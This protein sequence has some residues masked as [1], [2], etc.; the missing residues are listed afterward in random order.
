MLDYLKDQIAK[1]TGSGEPVSQ[2]LSSD[3]ILEYASL[4]Q[5]LDDLSGDGT[6]GERGGVIDI[7]LDESFEMDTVEINLSDGRLVDV[8]MDAAVQEAMYI[9]KYD[10][11]YQEACE[12]IQP[13]SHRESEE[14]LESRRHDYA[15]KLQQ[16]YVGSLKLEGVSGFSNI[17]IKDDSVPQSSKIDFGEIKTNIP[18]AYGLESGGVITQKQI[19][20]LRICEQ[21]FGSIFTDVIMESTGLESPWDTMRPIRLCI[22]T[23]YEG[24]FKAQL[25]TESDINGIETYTIE[26]PAE[27]VQELFNGLSI[28]EKQA[29]GKKLTKQEEET[30]RLRD[31][32]LKTIDKT[33][34]TLTAACKGFG[35]SLGAAIAKGKEVKECGDTTGCQTVKEYKE[36]FIQTS[37]PSRFGDQIVQEGIDF[38]DGGDGE[39]QNPLP[40]DGTTTVDTPAIDMASTD[41]ETPTADQPVVADD[42]QKVDS[43]DV[44]DQIAQNVADN[45]DGGDLDGATAELDGTD[46]PSA[47]EGDPEF[48]TNPDDPEAQLSDLDEPADTDDLDIDVT[49]LDGMSI[50]DL[51]KA[52]EQRL[53]AM[54]VEE[55]KSFITDVGA[56]AIEGDDETQVEYAI[57]LLQA[58]KT[59]ESLLTE[60]WKQEAVVFQEALFLNKKNIKKE[61]K[62]KLSMSLGILNNSEMEIEKILS[63]FKKAGKPLNRVLSKAAKMKKLFNEEDCGTFASLNKVLSDLMSTI[64]TDKKPTEGESQVLRRLLQEFVSQSKAVDAILEKKDDDKNGGGE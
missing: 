10:T 21:Y 2:D 46:T 60:S 45:Q 23:N 11:F 16:E 18:V 25:V 38:G 58:I 4:F 39:Q 44:S 50:N 22:P 33:K 63:E 29:K 7:P 40:A 64:K 54:S 32:Q 5:E 37:R 59:T 17:S 20:T 9:K 14:S 57:G 12:A 6:S 49:N 62:D 47:D 3:T 55:L 24:T 61:V 15:R 42:A 52:G 30:L 56:E 35:T 27:T 1:A 53:K 13:H 43:N 26:A 41:G 28:A 48:N 51:L 31:E 34:E 8:P 36:F 19:N